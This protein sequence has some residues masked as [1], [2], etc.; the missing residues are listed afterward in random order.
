MNKAETNQNIL[1]ENISR[2]EKLER[3]EI[4]F[5]LSLSEKDDINQLSQLANEEKSKHVQNITYFRGLLEFSN[6]CEKNCFYCGIRKGNQHINRYQLSREEIIQAAEFAWKSRYGSIV[7]QSGE[8]S[9][10]KSVNFICDILQEIRQKTNGELGITLSCGEHTKENYQRFFEAG[11]HRYLLRIE[12]TDRE[13]YYKIHPKNA[14]HNFENRLNCLYLLK[15]C[16]YQVG[17]GVMVGLPGQ[18]ISSLAGDLLFFR[19]FDVDMVGLGPYIEHSQT[20]L[21]K[22]AQPELSREQRFHLTLNMISVLRLMMKNINIAAATALQAIDLMGREK[23][24]KAGANIIMPNITPKKYRGDYL[25]YEDKPCI[26]EDAEECKDCLDW[27][28]RMI[29]DEIGYGKWGDSQHF[30]KRINP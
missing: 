17:T 26:D 23:A 6:H 18:T 1:I 27:R 14:L 3:N 9:D 15:E 25:L 22:M 5:L 20:P 12:T 21:F 28:I 13:L 24:L 7:L 4:E 30:D 16:G 11:A 2:K 10:A 19:D 29:G 8:L